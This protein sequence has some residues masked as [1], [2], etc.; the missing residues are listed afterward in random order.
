M[1]ASGEAEPAGL[2]AQRVGVG[3]DPASSSLVSSQQHHTPGPAHFV[4]GLHIPALQDGAGGG[5]EGLLG[6]VRLVR[7]VQLRLLVGGGVV[8]LGVRVRQG[9]G[10]VGRSGV[11]RR[12]A[13]AVEEAS[14]R[15]RA[16]RGGRGRGV[17]GRHGR[18]TEATV[19]RRILR[20]VNH[21]P[22]EDTEKM[23]K[24]KW[25]RGQ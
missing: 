23:N 5:S 2:G 9:V 13:A 8:R 18:V 21:L 15:R 11:R 16:L 19:G 22:L 20:C 10:V 6:V 1:G 3:I 24:T 4:V 25:M 14:T 17:L 7:L 12:P